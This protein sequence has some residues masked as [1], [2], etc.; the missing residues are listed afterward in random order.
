[1]KASMGEAKTDRFCR[2]FLQTMDPLQAGRDCWVKDPYE[3][4]QRP[5]VQQKLDRARACVNR[6]IR[7]EDVIR[8]LAQLC[9]GGAGDA[10]RLAFLQPGEEAQL[11]ELE[12]S[13][14]TEFK[15]GSNGTVEV[16]LVDRVKAL[17]LLYELLGGEKMGLSEFYEAL[18]Q[19]GEE[20]L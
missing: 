16:K 13:A 10:A 15:R 5:Q 2:R 19:A 11:D 14:V 18:E 17:Q 6:E 12:L 9:F 1:M 3:V 20:T 7:R 4:L 8:R